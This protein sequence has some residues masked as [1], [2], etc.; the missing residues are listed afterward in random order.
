MDCEYSILIVGAAILVVPATQ[1]QTAYDDLVNSLL[2]A[3]LV[4]NKQME[5]DQSTPWYD[6]YMQFLDDFWPR[7]IKGRE[8]WR[9]DADS[10]ES[11]VD[12][13][14]PTISKA[15]PAAGQD[16][17][18]VLTRLVNVPATHPAINLLRTHMKKV[19]G[20]QVMPVPAP[21]ENVHLLVLMAQSPTT[22]ASV[23]V[24][25]KTHQALSL[26]PLAQLYSVEDIQGPVTLRYARANLSQVSYGFVR[27]E[28]ALKVKERI[29]ENV[30]TFDMN[31]EPGL[32]EEKQP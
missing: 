5:K 9:I 26:N 12:W 28:V 31:D 10:H 23:F 18:R 15:S 22:F 7:D 4:A 14:V 3:Q 20:A 19:S 24:E 16:I 11:F 21:A 13:I 32:T 2:F 27:D 25:L 30:A 6:C 1:D 8:D 29:A 17:D